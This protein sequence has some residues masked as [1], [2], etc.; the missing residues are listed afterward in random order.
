MSRWV[1]TG[2]LV[3]VSVACQK[4]S[5]NIADKIK[6]E[7]EQSAKDIE[8]KS[9][10]LKKQQAEVEV[11][12][13]GGQPATIYLSKNLTQ[14]STSGHV[15]PIESLK[16]TLRGGVSKNSRRSDVDLQKKILIDKSEVPAQ[17][18]LSKAGTYINI[19]CNNLPAADIGELKEEKLKFESD[20]LRGKDFLTVMATRIFFCGKASSTHPLVYVSAEEI[21]LNDATIELK[22]DLL[23]LAIRAKILG[24]R[25]N[26]KILHK[27]KQVSL[28]SRSDDAKISI[29]VDQKTHGTGTLEIK[30]DG[31]NYFDSKK[32]LNSKF[33]SQF[34]ASGLDSYQSSS[35][36]GSEK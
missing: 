19:G 9:A 17:S 18:E 29:I 23:N 11:L 12:K 21:Y 6:G 36:S 13:V 14:E 8:T 16:I 28:E 26:S 30:S 24:L 22:E 4:R 3:L 5:Q 7:A 25:G 20:K 32:L 33:N 1:L 35:N 27:G 31:G 34:S 10:D 2:L 15:T